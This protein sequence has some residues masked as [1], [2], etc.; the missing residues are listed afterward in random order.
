MPMEITKYYAEGTAKR[1]V[2]YARVLVK[3]H[4]R[5]HFTTE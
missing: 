3:L 1:I 5:K 4:R 2:G